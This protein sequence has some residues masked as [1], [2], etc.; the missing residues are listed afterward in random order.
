MIG[1]YTISIF[2][3]LPEY[4]YASYIPHP[5][6]KDHWICKSTMDMN[7]ERAYMTSLELLV[8]YIPLVVISVTQ[9]HAYKSLQQSAIQFGMT[10]RRMRIM[11]QVFNT[12]IIVV[13]VFFLLTT[14]I[15]FLIL[16]YYWYNDREYLKSNEDLINDIF[17]ALNLLVTM[18]SC[19]NPVIYGSVNDR[20][21]HFFHSTIRKK[22]NDVIKHDAPSRCDFSFPSYHMIRA[23]YR[24]S[25]VVSEEICMQSIKLVKRPNKV[26]KRKLV[27]CEAFQDL[28]H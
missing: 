20:V 18:N 8:V 10:N 9:Y 7:F 17:S 16:F 27:D 26:D 3:V 12:F 6:Q 11:K 15:S 5:K 1:I 23:A 13:A 21:V 19:V 14:P 22:S 24:P 2:A 4:H 28:K 25:L